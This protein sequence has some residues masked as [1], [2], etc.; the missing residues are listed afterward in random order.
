MTT[1][2]DESLLHYACQC[3]TCDNIDV[4]KYLINKQQLNPLL[5]DNVNQL[6]PL[7][8]AVNNN[9]YSITEYICQYYISSDKMLSP[10]R[11]KTT[12]NLLRYIADPWAHSNENPILWKIADGD[13]ILQLVGSSKICIACIYGSREVQFPARRPFP[14]AEGQLRM[15]ANV[16][17]VRS[18]LSVWWPRAS[19]FHVRSRLLNTNAVPGPK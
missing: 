18:Y 9:Q 12:I 1:K 8:Y 6:E 13:N 16:L 7:D 14:H 5:R 11:I 2:R 10:N 3:D 17:R 4:V 19:V 15:R